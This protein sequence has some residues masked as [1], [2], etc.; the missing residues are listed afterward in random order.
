MTFPF[1]ASE[2]RV[3]IIAEDDLELML[4][5]KS[6]PCSVCSILTTFRCDEC[7]H[8]AYC[9]KGCRRS[10]YSKHKAICLRTAKP[11]TFSTPSRIFRNKSFK[12]EDFQIGPDQ[13]INPPDTEEY[14]DV[15]FL[16]RWHSKILMLAKVQCMNISDVTILVWRTHRDRD[17]LLNGAV[18][19]TAALVSASLVVYR[20]R[21]SCIVYLKI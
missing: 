6:S 1:T 16:W 19:F 10:D 18:K 20:D 17:Y 9:S 7:K 14:E 3:G 11:Y 8:T 15:Q 2:Y 5:K 13:S 12:V 4:N 21:Q